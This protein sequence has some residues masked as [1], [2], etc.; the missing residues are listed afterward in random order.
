M[1]G[2]QK[3]LHNLTFSCHWSNI[4]ISPSGLPLLVYDLLQFMFINGA[5]GN[6]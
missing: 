6:K 3:S 2:E 4:F 1:E 5:L